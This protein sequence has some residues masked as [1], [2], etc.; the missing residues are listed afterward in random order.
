MLLVSAPSPALLAQHSKEAAFSRVQHGP[1][2]LRAAAGSTRLVHSDTDPY[3][4]EGAP[5]AY[6]GLRLDADV[7]I[8]SGGHLDPEARYGAGDRSRTEHI[9]YRGLPVLARF[10]R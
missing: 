6:A 5:V 4:L 10:S 7:V 9:Y 3:W 8:P 2:A 1:A